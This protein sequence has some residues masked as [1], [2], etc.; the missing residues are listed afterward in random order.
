MS[1]RPR[2]GGLRARL[3]VAF[4][5]VALLGTIVSTVYSSVSVTSRLEASARTRLNHSATHFGDVA[6][7]VS[8]N[9]AWTRQSVETLHHLAQI[10]FLAVDLYD[11]TGKLVFS[12]PRP[13]RCRQA[14]RRRR[15]SW[16]AARRSAP[17]S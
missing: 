17:W 6:A 16:W 12:H 7:V 3:L 1:D 2:R 5:A 4:V 15:R 13:R 9:G 8:R 14:R 11:A 10:D